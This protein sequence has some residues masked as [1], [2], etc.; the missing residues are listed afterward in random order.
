METGNLHLLSTYLKKW[1]YQENKLS[2]SYSFFTEQGYGRDIIDMRIGAP[3]NMVNEFLNKIVYKA[4]DIISSQN[5]SIN[6]SVRFVN[7]TEVQRKLNVFLSKILR[8]FNTNK[9]SRGRIR[10]ISNRSM[11]FYYNDF[12]YEPL[13]DDTKFYVHLKKIKKD[14]KNKEMPKQKTETTKPASSYLG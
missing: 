14:L 11:D 6:L 1:S 12:E 5:E 3:Q 13:D 4:K 2:L 8:E 10:M 9:R 7:E